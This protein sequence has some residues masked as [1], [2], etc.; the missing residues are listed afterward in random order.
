MMM[1]K[2]ERLLRWRRNLATKKKSKFWRETSLSWNNQG[3]ARW[4][5]SKT[6]LRSYRKNI[7]SSKKRNLDLLK[8]WRNCALSMKALGNNLKPRLTNT[9][10]LTMN[11]KNCLINTEIRWITSIKSSHWEN[12]QNK[13]WK[14][15]MMKQIKFLPHTRK[16][17]KLSRMNVRRCKLPFINLWRRT[18]SCE[19][20]WG[21][22]SQLTNISIK[23]TKESWSKRTLTSQLWQRK[24]LSKNF[25]WFLR[26]VMPISQTAEAGRTLHQPAEKAITTQLM[27]LTRLMPL[28][29]IWLLILVD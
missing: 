29:S 15:N 6:R 10:F 28:S 13:L 12:R 17:F 5:S 7:R 9:T 16:M 11:I 22:K 21:N 19:W 20:I 14:S 8:K 1:R 27:I 4:V 24:L 18:K 3:K 23:T 2:I 25:S 26:S